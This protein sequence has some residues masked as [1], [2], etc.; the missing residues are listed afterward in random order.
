MAYG[1]KNGWKERKTCGSGEEG[2][3]DLMKRSE[4]QGL[5]MA[6][7]EEKRWEESKEEGW[8]DGSDD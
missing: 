1:G 6:L 8:R 5:K 7:H 3:S 2:R 4:K